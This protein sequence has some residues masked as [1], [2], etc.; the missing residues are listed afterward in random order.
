MLIFNFI[1]SIAL[2]LIIFLVIS[3]VIKILL[4]IFTKF[5]YK[6]YYLLLPTFLTLGA[7]SLCFL[8]WYF[9][10]TYFLK[11]NIT[12]VII[13]FIIKEG[14]IKNNFIITSLTYILIAIF[15]QS[16]AMLAINIDYKKMTGNTRFF[17]KKL[18]KIRM[19]KNGKL[20]IKNEP[21]KISFIEALAISI[22]TF[23]III[24]TIALLF[25]IGYIISKNLI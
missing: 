1:I 25:F 12:K 8:L 20:I 13:S 3:S 4:Y 21:E 7:W 22:L 24:I 9:T 10:I 19:K 23:L 11:I 16:I 17:F 15:L 5:E 2:I 6:S 14:Y 18:F